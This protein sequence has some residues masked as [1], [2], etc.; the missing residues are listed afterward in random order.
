[1]IRIPVAIVTTW[2][3]GSGTVVMWCHHQVQMSKADMEAYRPTIGKPF[4]CLECAAE[5]YRG[6]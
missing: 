1:M 4:P 6:E 5:I 2:D 3:D